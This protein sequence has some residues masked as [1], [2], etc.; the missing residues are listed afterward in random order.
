MHQ[1]YT[2][3]VFHLKRRKRSFLMKNAIEFDDPDHSIQE[4]RFLL[5]GLS[6]SLKV[7][8]VC[9]FIEP[10]NLKYVLFQRGKQLKRD[11]AFILGGH[12]EKKN[13]ILKK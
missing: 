8:I 13:T 10:L 9:H 7:L 6:Q 5:L 3:T 12:D 2:S 1:I 11:K 4:E